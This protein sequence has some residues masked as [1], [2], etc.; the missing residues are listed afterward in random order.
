[1]NHI[2]AFLFGNSVEYDPRTADRKGDA[3]G[4]MSYVH[5]MT[6]GKS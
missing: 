5:G 6:F 1:M 2:G 4:H 3:V